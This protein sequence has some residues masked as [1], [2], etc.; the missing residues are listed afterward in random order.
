M[1]K[2]L[3]IGLGA[4][5]VLIIL[6]IPLIAALVS[7]NNRLVAL[8]EN[9]HSAWG[10]VETVLQRRY[11]LIP[12]L[13]QTVKG[14]A[15]HES[16][17]LEE[18][19]RLRSQWG[20]AGTAAEKVQAAGQLEG[21][22]ARLLLVVERY[23]ELKA[24]ARFRDLQYELAGTENRIAVERQRYNDAARAY[25]TAVRQFPGSLVAAWRGLAAD[26]TYFEAAST[27]KEVPKV[28]F[29]TEK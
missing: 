4:V 29:G 6:S 15:K 1:K 2:A 21:S 9:V 14:Y 10:Q 16:G 28:D 23:P 8:Q 5:G 22:L 24:D 11:D 18:V 26:A 7:L 3:L 27:A 17:I 13:V 20:S 19:T 25:N 12:N